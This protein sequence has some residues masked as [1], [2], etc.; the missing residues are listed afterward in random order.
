VPGT[1]PRALCYL[2]TLPDPKRSAGRVTC[3]DGNLAATLMG[4]ESC[5]DGAVIDTLSSNQRNANIHQFSL[6]ENRLDD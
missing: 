4:S 5:C 3:C 2:L 6:F 1:Y